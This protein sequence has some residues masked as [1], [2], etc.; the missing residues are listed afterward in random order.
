[1]RPD[2][3]D[4]REFIYEPPQ[5]EPIEILHIDEALLCVNKPADLLSVPGRTENLADCLISRLHL[6]YPEALLVHR[7]DV[8]TSGVMVFARTREAQRHLGLQFEKRF[9][10]KTY[11]AQVYGHTHDSGHIN[12][13]LRA[14]WPERPRQMVC[15]EHGKSAQTDWVKLNDNQSSSRLSLH[16]ITGRS[17]QL[18]VHMWAMGHP[19]L[20][21]RI[22]APDEAFRAAPRL[23]LHAESLTLR[24]PN[25][26]KPIT[27]TTPCPN[28]GL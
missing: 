16:P 21:D 1:M 17:H 13:P 20:G 15:F 4:R 27:I 19:I 7:L 11:I 9:T 22:Y 24:H 12:L 8:A 28:F 5:L 3:P 23:C 6:Q 14:D 2:L 26:G 25:G 18:R 10:E